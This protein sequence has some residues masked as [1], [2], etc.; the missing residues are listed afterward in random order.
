MPRKK[1]KA[2]HEGN[3]PLL[4]DT[5]GSLGWITLEEI[6][7][8]MSEALEKSFDNFY[9]LNTENLKE[10]RATRQRSASLEQDARQPRLTTEADVKP[11]TKTRKRTENAAAE[12]VISE[13]SSFAQ[14]D[15][16]LMCLTSFGD[17]STKYLAL[18]CCRD[19]ALIG[20]GAAV[21]NPCL[22]PV[23]MRTLT[24]AGGLLPTGTVSTAMRTIVSRSLF[25]W[26]LG[27]Q[28]TYQPDKQPACP[29]LLV[30][31]YLNKVNANSGVRSW[32]DGSR[33]SSM[34]GTRRT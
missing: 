22:S 27:D 4:Q 16:D 15:P 29:L 2:V 34:F 20:K 25:S 31:G 17:D 19:D 11:G 18:P 24:A 10:M 21:L 7:R 26:S 14:V 28:E 30:K 13:D 33:G 3:D 9:R 5:C 23:K 32:S 6:R 1:S 8:I 12:R